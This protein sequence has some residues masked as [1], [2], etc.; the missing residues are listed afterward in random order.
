[1]ISSAAATAVRGRAKLVADVGGEPC[2]AFDAGFQG[3]R[4]RVERVS[5]PAQVGVVDAGQSGV[6][7]AVGDPLGGVSDGAERSHEPPSRGAAYAGGHQRRAGDP[8]GERAGEQVEG[9]VEFIEREELEVQAIRGS[10]REHPRRIAARR[11]RPGSAG[12]RRGRR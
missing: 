4:H 2:L 12:G 6:E 9:P 5:E 8:E 10:D 11:L 7:R 3:G 1:M